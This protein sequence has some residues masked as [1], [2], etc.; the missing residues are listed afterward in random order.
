MCLAAIYWARL[1]RVYFANTRA[2]AARIGFDDA[3]I[4]DEIPKV[5]EARSLPMTRLRLL[6]ADAIFQEWET[7]ANKVPY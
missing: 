5:P 6:A 2:D 7:K 1:G 4:Y 3:W